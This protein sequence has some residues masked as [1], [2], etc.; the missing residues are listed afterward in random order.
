MTFNV[1]KFSS[2][3]QHPALNHYSIQTNKLKC[4]NEK[5]IKSLTGLVLNKTGHPFYTER[6]IKAA[7][8]FAV[9]RGFVCLLSNRPIRDPSIC[10]G[11]N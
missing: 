6:K 9:P 11:K 7:A 4:N 2:G 10:Q 5:N 8:L 3:Y 1:Y